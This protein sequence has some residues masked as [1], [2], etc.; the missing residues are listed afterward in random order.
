MIFTRGIVAALLV[1]G[2][3]ATVSAQRTAK[4]TAPS[5]VPI[6]AVDRVHPLVGTS[7]E[8]QTYPAAGVPF[9]MT[10][11]T[12]QTRAGEIKCVAPYYYGDTKLQGFRAS[13]FLSGSCVPDY[14]SVT[15]M[16]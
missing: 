2:S 15:L 9:A 11:W 3:A 5:G 14:G 13:H 7:G 16:A 6:A 10:Q 4:K 8:G 12:P 1:A